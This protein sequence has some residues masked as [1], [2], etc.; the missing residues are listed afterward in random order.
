M[1]MKGKV[2]MRR[3]SLAVWALFFSLAGAAFL[4]GCI[5]PI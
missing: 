4:G 1:N 2:G 5:N 3:G